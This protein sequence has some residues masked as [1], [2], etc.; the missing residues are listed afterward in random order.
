MNQNNKK[1]IP[2]LLIILRSK[3][4]KGFFIALETLYI[5]NR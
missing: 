2:N 1:E 5:I 3:E 4:N